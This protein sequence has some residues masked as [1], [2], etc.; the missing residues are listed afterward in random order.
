MSRSDI[1]SYSDSREARIETSLQEP[2]CRAAFRDGASEPVWP[3]RIPLGEQG[4]LK[5]GKLFGKRLTLGI[6]AR[7]DGISSREQ[8]WT[9]RSRSNLD[10]VGRAS[11]RLRCAA[12]LLHD[13]RYG[14]ILLERH[15]ISANRMVRG[16]F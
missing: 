8:L 3:R 10:G 16:H 2:S 1:S 15:R 14:G 4:I 12:P 11:Y 9:P 7:A 5:G 13:G 6:G